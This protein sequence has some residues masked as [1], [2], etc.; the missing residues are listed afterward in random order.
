M[1]KHYCVFFS[2]AIHLYILFL[3]SIAQYCSRNQRPST[4]NTGAHHL[5]TLHRHITPLS[6]LTPLFIEVYISVTN[7]VFQVVAILKF[8]L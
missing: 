8:Y 1:Y 4:Y 6:S 3:I 7:S 5:S 2:R